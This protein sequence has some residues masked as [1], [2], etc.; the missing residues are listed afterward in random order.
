TSVTAATPTSVRSNESGLKPPA[1]HARPA[2]SAN[3]AQPAAGPPSRST[4]GLSGPGGGCAPPPGRGSVRWAR[5]RLRRRSD[6]LAAGPACV[7]QPRDRRLEADG[8]RAPV[9]DTVG[10]RLLEARPLVVGER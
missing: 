3:A 7:R 9:A 8:R 5:M 4:P 10:E 2:V 1:S 6:G